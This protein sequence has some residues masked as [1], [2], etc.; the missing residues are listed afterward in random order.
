MLADMAI[1]LELAR[2]ATYRAASDLDQGIR[3]SYFASVAKCFA[4]DS[5]MQAA[6]NAVQ[7]LFLEFCYL[8]ITFIRVLI[9]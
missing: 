6:L 1:N 4:A 5:A 9:L 7:V 8:I 2:L 3:N